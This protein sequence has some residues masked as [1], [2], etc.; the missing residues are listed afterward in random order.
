MDKALR[1]L[2]DISHKV[3][4]DTR[5]VQGGGGN[6]SC[7]TEN[8]TFM[9]VKASGTSLADMDTNRGWRKMDIQEVIKILEDDKLMRRS[10]DIRETQVMQK[11]AMCCEDDFGSDSRPSVEAPLHAFLDK[12][13]IHLH[14]QA[15]GAYVNCKNGREKIENIFAEEK[16]PMLWVPYVDPGLTLARK[17]YSL[18]KKYLKQYEFL[19]E[20]I[21]LEKHGLFVSASS[22]TKALAI[23]RRVI[24]KC[25]HSLN[26]LKPGRMT[27]P[28]TEQI[29]HCK[30]QIRKALFD[31]A[32][33]RQCVQFFINDT[34]KGFLQHKDA[35]SMLS[36]GPLSPDELVYAN[37]PALWIDNCKSDKITKKLNYISSKGQKLPA[38]FLVKKTGLFVSAEPKTAKVINDVAKFSFYVRY[39]AN[40]IGKI[41]ALNKRQ[42]S[43]I[44]DWEA[45]SFRK[46][47][48]GQAGAPG[49]LKNRIAIV[50]GAGS[51]LGKSIAMG[52]AQD[53]ALV[54]LADID[55]Q[56]AE[57]TKKQIQEKLAK[58]SIVLKCNVTSEESVRTAFNQLLEN[59]GGL[60]IL[61][62]AAGVAPAYPMHQTPVDKWRFALE[63]N[64]TG[65][66]LMA[67]IAADIMKK[68]GIG[69]SI[70]NISSK[71]GI[72]ASK[73]NSAYNATKA[74]QLH[75]T[76]GWAMELGQ[77][78]IRV[79]SI[80][81][82]NVFEGSRIWNPQYIKVCAKK[83]NIKPEEV[84]PFYV[85]KTML[86]LEI[87]G[88]DIADAVVFLS[89]DNAR[90][91]TGQ[92][93][94]VDA[95]QAIVR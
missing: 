45:E 27:D 76:R 78:N 36:A 84:I 79:N 92:T 91:I 55:T 21:F 7:K 43:F 9:F 44:N 70:V 69:G 18:V 58:Q 48:S 67:K 47:V 89:S 90:R 38:A 87:K 49:R 35:P 19:P 94:V 37:G 63:V 2:I 83:Y 13:V 93:L 17:T 82:G 81:P 95:G 6:T 65:Y 3:G 64:L 15:V 61:V 22:Q 12:V 50:T 20:I 56:A 1:E 29:N 88:R 60:D 46:K 57:H 10:P 34:V 14:P 40:R 42:R 74:G 86:K 59:W 33:K 73:N 52:L 77:D 53:G 26:E 16:K 62:N 25:S 80:C 72:D 31:A 41:A 39:N 66:M 5:L 68:Q 75:L 28:Q 30:L 23:V 32:G 71:T 85:N 24:K 4:T 54:G 51:G 11:M 8:G